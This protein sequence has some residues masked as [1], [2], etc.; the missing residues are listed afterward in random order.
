M[1]VYRTLDRV[2]HLSLIYSPG[3]GIPGVLKREHSAPPNA[4]RPGGA[5][6]SVDRIVLSG[7]A[8]KILA[9]LSCFAR[10]YSMLF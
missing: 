8:T 1:V 2:A 4:R 5:N 10:N 3:S 7:T 9:I 6:Q